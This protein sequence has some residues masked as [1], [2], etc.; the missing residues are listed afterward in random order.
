MRKSFIVLGIAALLG[1][2]G[3]ACSNPNKMVEAASQVQVKC[4]PAVLEA[5]AD[6]IEARYTVSF[7]AKFFHPKAIVEITPVL[8]YEGGEEATVSKWLQGENVT[9]NHTVIP[10]TGGGATQTVQFAWKPGMEAARLELRATLQYKGRTTAFPAPFKLADGTIVTYK[11]VDTDGVAVLAPDAYQKVYTETREAQIKYIINSAVVRSSELSKTDIKALESFLAEAEQDARKQ[12]KGTDIIAYASPD[13]P[14]DLNTG[15]SSNRGKTAKDALTK[16]TRKVKSQGVVNV[17]SIAEDWDGFRELVAESNVPD[18]DLIL[19]VLSMYTDPVVR[20]R[21]IK[22]MSKVYQI[23]A[24]KV[25]PEL[26]RARLVAQVDV[27]NYSDEEL[28]ALVRQNNLEALD[29]EALL[30]AAT[31][32]PDNAS[33]ITVYGKAAQKFNNWRAYNNLAY[34]YLAEGR[35]SDAKTA[36]AKITTEND[37]VN[38][39]NG[40]VALRE[41]RIQDAERLLISIAT[42]QARENMGA[43]AIIKGSYTDAVTKLANTGS[44]N[45]ALAGVLVKNYDK[46]SNILKNLDSAKAHYLNAVIAAR[47][48]NA[49]Q[50]AAELQRAY[51]QDASLK[52]RAQTDVEFAKVKDSI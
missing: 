13:G 22:N 12:A 48:G 1:M 18:K 24:D 42:P 19:R 8:V 43:I 4:E 2:L 36:L 11:L 44:F 16:A 15:L 20:E 30:Y 35:T 6:I 23:L 28:V 51:A 21:E 25:L 41:G 31:L 27:S 9:E 3:A 52:T 33:K 10:K 37:I 46:A 7:P 14:L 32:V 45:E 26:R 47:N 40:I 34:V 17:S 39:N 5:R 49:S 50:V 38:T 29:V